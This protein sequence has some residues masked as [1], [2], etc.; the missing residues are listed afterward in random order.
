MNEEEWNT[1]YDVQI[2]AVS[3]FSFPLHLSLQKLMNKAIRG[4][5]AA[6]HLYFHIIRFF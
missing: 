2:T 3:T 6:F 5:E 4:E 1:V